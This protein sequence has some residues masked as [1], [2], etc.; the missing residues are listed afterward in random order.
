[1][2][3]GADAKRQDA[4][5]DGHKPLKRA[6][7]DG[8]RVLIDVGGTQLST[9]LS[10]IE[11]SSYLLGMVDLSSWEQDPGAPPSETRALPGSMRSRPTP[12]AAASRTG[13]SAT[14]FLDRDPEIFG[15]LLRLMRQAPHVAGLLP[16]DPRLCASLIAEAD[17]FG[18]GA[19]IDHVK[20]RAHHHCIPSCQRCSP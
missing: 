7:A 17:F 12:I 6:R 8:Q 20:V 1:M 11:R 19:L 16:E 15:Q 3:T 5:A 18:Y 14:I 2:Q 10:T 13:H 9:T 4:L